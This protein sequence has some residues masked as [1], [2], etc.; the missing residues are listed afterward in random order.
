MKEELVR[1]LQSQYEGVFDEAQM[2]RFLAD[3]VE[4][5]P[6]QRLVDRVEQVA[7]GAGRRW[8]D[9]GC[10]FGSFVLAARMRGIQ[11]VG[12]DIAPFEVGFA[13]KRLQRERPQDDPN[14]VYLL[15][16]GRDLPFE[17][18]I[19]DVITLWNVLEHVPEA[20]RLL[21]EAYRV[22]RPG[23]YLFIVCPNYMAFRREAHYQVPWIPLMPR[24]LAGYYLRVMGKNPRFFAEGIFYRSNWA[25]LRALRRMGMVVHDTRAAKLAN[26]VM[27]R[28]PKLQRVVMTLD[29]FRLSWVIRLWFRMTFYNPL[30]PTVEFYA[31]KRA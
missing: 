7:D 14:T 18:G 25:V 1:Y 13:R 9:V 12:V 21:L 4:L 23:G 26:P 2:H 28:H 30:R 16:D 27:I 11:A 22:L 6:A 15:A 29:R 24:G 31:V 20:E 19:F 3:Y 8:L 10:G 17:A 5:A